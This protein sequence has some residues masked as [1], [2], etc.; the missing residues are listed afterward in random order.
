MIECII[1]S[2]SITANSYIVRVIADPSNINAISYYCIRDF[3]TLNLLTK[4]PLTRHSGQYNCIQV[5]NLPNDLHGDIL[6][7][8]NTDITV[9]AKTHQ[10]ALQQLPWETRT[11]CGDD[12]IPLPANVPNQQAIHLDRNQIEQMYAAGTRNFV[13]VNLMNADL[14]NFNLQGADFRDSFFQNAILNDVDFSST[15]LLA[16]DLSNAN[17]TNANLGQVVLHI[18][19]LQNAD[20]SHAKLHS[21]NLRY[22][23]IINANLQHAELQ[24]SDLRNANLR[25]ANL[26]NTYLSDANLCDACFRFANLQNAYF[27]GATL[28]NTNLQDANCQNTN[29][30]NAE[31]QNANFQH[32]NL[33]SANIR[34]ASLGSANLQNATLQNA[35]LRDV[36]LQNANLRNTD[37]KSAN[38]QGANLNNATFAG[39]NIQGTNFTNTKISGTIFENC[40]MDKNTLFAGGNAAEQKDLLK[41]FCKKY[42]EHRNEWTSF[43]SWFWPDFSNSIKPQIEANPAKAMLELLQYLEKYPGSNEATVWKEIYGKYEYKSAQATNLSTEVKQ[44]AI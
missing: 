18:A 21:A 37:L 20:L 10:V 25:G 40:I 41:I 22:A 36:F 11:F 33:N 17:L 32:V 15:I 12:D 42:T 23:N 30:Q 19:I 28:Q 13:G 1:T 38:F 16:A 4:C 14:A 26:Q 34:N 24:N 6:K 44:L 43:F 35:D 5:G 2:E 27:F 3:K 39:A 31:L 7:Q 29:F 9:W 8:I